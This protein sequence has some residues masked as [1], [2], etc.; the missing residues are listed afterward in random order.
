[1]RASFFN[2][3]PADT[4]NVSFLLFLIAIT[5]FFHDSI[6]ISTMLV[7]VFT[8]LIATQIALSKYGRTNTIL[9]YTYDLVFPFFCILIIFESLGYMVHTVQPRD[10]DH[11]LVKIDYMIFHGHPTVLLER[12]INPLL[13]DIMQLAYISYYFLPIILGISLKV[14]KNDQLFDRSLFLIIFCFYLSYIGYLL[15]PALGPR[16]TINHLHALDLDG[17][18]IFEPIQEALNWLEGNKRDAFPSGHTG[19]ALTVLYCAYLYEKKIFWI[20]LPIVILL[21]LSTVYCRYHYVVDVLAGILLA[22]IT[23]VIGNGY[24]EFREKRVNSNR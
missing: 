6:R 16:Y 5:F 3:R 15:M 1:M 10:I 19:V 23:I 2:I 22:F 24:Y 17:W 14:K 12:F 18:I 9:E 4:L 20:Y 21:I 8:V 7:I 13:T 11:I